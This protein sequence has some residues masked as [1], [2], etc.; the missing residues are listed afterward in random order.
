MVEIYIEYEKARI[1]PLDNP[2]QETITKRTFRRVSFEINH[3]LKFIKDK[4]YGLGRSDNSANH[5]L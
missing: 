3:Y 1:N 2:E 4:E 5:F